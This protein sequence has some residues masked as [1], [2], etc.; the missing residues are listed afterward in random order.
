MSPGADVNQ[1]SSSSITWTV[2]V[3]SRHGV[4]PACCIAVLQENAKLHFGNPADFVLTVPE[5]SVK[6]GEVVAI[7]GR[8]GCGK[9]WPNRQACASALQLTC[10]FQQLL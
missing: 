4:Q 7:V 9:Q 3:L 5:F 2:S 8:V 6:P 10:N 1:L